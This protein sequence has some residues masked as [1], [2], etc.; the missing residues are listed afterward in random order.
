MENYKTVH[1]YVKTLVLNRMEEAFGKIIS[2][3]RKTLE[4]W[5]DLYHHNIA[6]FR[7]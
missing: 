6:R 3:E 1:I 2:G 4:G 7:E 5:K